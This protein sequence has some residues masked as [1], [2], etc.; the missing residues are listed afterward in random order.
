MAGVAPPSKEQPPLAYTAYWVEKGALTW[1]PFAGWL[2]LGGAD[3]LA[4]SSRDST[5]APT[6]WFSSARPAFEETTRGGYREAQ[7]GAAM[8]AL[9]CQ[10]Q[11]RRT[12]DLDPAGKIPAG[13]V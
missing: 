6:I 7:N 13:N 2:A 4:T 12:E 8:H 3:D 9:P 5:R 11:P 1:Q 10:G